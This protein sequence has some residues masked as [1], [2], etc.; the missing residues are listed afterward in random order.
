MK[1]AARIIGNDGG[2][3]IATVCSILPSR[4]ER[5]HLILIAGDKRGK[6]AKQSQPRKQSEYSKLLLNPKWQKKRLEILERDEFT[7][8]ICFNTENTLHVHHC[9]YSKGRKPWEYEDSSLKTLCADC[10]A[11]ETELGYS[12]RNAFAE[13][14]CRI[15]L[16]ESDF[17][18]LA[19]AIDH[20]LDKHGY[21]DAGARNV[22][23]LMSY[24][25]AFI[26][27]PATFIE[28]EK[29]TEEGK[30]NAGA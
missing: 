13:S 19:G 25:S 10:H 11:Q 18:S 17:W 12:G 24:I 6:M 5:P 16:T 29:S 3:G 2:S 20:S 15:G 26:R 7:C 1:Q 4:V 8:Q 23:V 14:L 27:N 9:Y 28:A 22:A 30:P 21:F